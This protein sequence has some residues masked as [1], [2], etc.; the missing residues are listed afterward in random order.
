MYTGLQIYTKYKNVIYSEVCKKKSELEKIVCKISS[1]SQEVKK[2]FHRVLCKTI[3]VGCMWEL[4]R[5]K[6]SSNQKE[7]MTLV[8]MFDFGICNKSIDVK[9]WRNTYFKFGFIWQY[10][11]RD[12]NFISWQTTDK[13]EKQ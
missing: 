1:F 2:K 4:E 5:F 8:R 13:E 10:E 6:I 12:W 3:A 9:G 7:Y 11:F